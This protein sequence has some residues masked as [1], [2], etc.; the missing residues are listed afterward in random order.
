MVFSPAYFAGWSSLCELVT[1]HT[2]GLQAGRKD[3][4]M[5]QMQ[6]TEVISVS[7]N[8]WRVPSEEN[9]FDGWI[10]GVPTEDMRRKALENAR[11]ERSAWKPREEGFAL[12]DQI[13]GWTGS[14][15]RIQLWSP[16]MYMLEDEGPFPIQAK[17]IGM[18]VQEDDGF[19]QAYML[20][21]EVQ[22]LPTMNGCTAMGF[23]KKSLSGDCGV[24]LAD[25]Y[26]IEKLAETDGI[27]ESSYVVENCSQLSNENPTVDADLGIPRPA[28]LINSADTYQR[29]NRG[30]FTPGSFDFLVRM[31]DIEGGVKQMRNSGQDDT[32]MV[33]LAETLKVSH[34]T[35]DRSLALQYSVANGKL[36]LDWVLLGERNAADAE[37][38]IAFAQAKGH[39]IEHLSENNV[40]FLRIED[41]DLAALG[42]EILSDFYGV[43]CAAELGLIINGI[44][45]SSGKR[46]LR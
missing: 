43:S 38:I 20:L 7:K 31:T 24:S 39:C 33:F 28:D 26:R 45:L 13:K 41:G 27:E 2:A 32:W 19:L 8:Y 17:L 36:G 37:E 1:K 40:K 14:Y 18:T 42:V 30:L 35:R 44:W 29:D 16:I 11:N 23:L 9:A 12:V 34:K 22:E 15:V 46:S 10:E 3:A 5:S 4:P 6:A 21:S 25:L